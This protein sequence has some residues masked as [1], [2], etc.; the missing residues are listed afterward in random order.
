MLFH[1][2]LVIF[3]LT[4]FHNYCIAFTIDWLDFNDINSIANFVEKIN[5]QIDN[6]YQLY[7]PMEYEEK[8]NVITVFAMNM[9]KIF[10]DFNVAFENSSNFSWIDFHKK[11]TQYRSEDELSPFCPHSISNIIENKLRT[12]E[13]IINYYFNF[14]ISIYINDLKDLCTF[15]ANS[16]IFFQKSYYYDLTSLFDIFINEIQKWNVIIKIF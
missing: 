15:A 7:H 6:D 11:I 1:K 14:K 4:I 2:I 12:I 9:L 13:N 3:L 5:S 16:T 10:E 8:E